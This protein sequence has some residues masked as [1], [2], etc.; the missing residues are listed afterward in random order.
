MTNVKQW[1]CVSEVHSFVNDGSD[2]FDG[3]DNRFQRFPHFGGCYSKWDGFRHDT[4]FFKIFI[5][6]LIGDLQCS[7]N[8]CCI[9]KWP[10][11]TYKYSFSHF[12]LHHVQSQV[13]RYSSLCYTAGSH[14][15]S[16]P[17]TIVCIYQPQTPRPSHSFPL[18]LGNHKSVPQVHAFVSFLWIGSFVPCIRFQI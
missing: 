10:S 16:T 1:R 2:L 15:F 7:V 14:C 17:N 13:T 3:L 5:F 11:H 12:I 8:F 18:T 9:A 4:L 6:S